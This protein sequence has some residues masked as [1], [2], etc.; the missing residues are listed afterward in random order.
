MS[1]LNLL[2]ESYVR[3]RYRNRIN[4]LCVIV[5]GLLIGVLI[6]L[7][8]G[9][10]QKHSQAIQDLK[11]SQTKVAQA[12]AAEELHL[13]AQRMLEK[14]EQEVEVRASYLCSKPT[15]YYLNKI[16]N[17]AAQNKIVIKD[18]RIERK[19]AAKTPSQKK[20]YQAFAK[21]KK[22]LEANKT[23][24]AK[25]K[26]SVTIPLLP[27]AGEYLRISFNIVAKDDTELRAFVTSIRE[28]K[29][30][31]GKK[32]FSRFIDGTQEEVKDGIELGL[33]LEVSRES[34]VFKAIELSKDNKE[35]K[36]R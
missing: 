9:S 21:A 15:S 7:E 3:Q 16:V 33:K 34:S 24:K 8:P 13:G 11:T 1:N 12:K 4:M 28:C 31:N 5:F 32:V 6:V 17:I 2:P 22:T 25:D 27:R 23:K 14:R 18:I 10:R 30:K 35:S 20:I 36:E 19:E 26:K 29:T